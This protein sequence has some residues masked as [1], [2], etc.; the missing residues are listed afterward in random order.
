MTPSRPLYGA[1]V[2]VFRAVHAE[3]ILRLPHIATL[4][5]V[6]PWAAYGDGA[7]GFTQAQMDAVHRNARSRLQRFGDRAVLVR[8]P[9]SKAVDLV[10]SGLDFVYIDG[11]HDYDNVRGDIQRW[12][13]KVNPGGI[14]GGHDF[15]EDWPGVIRAVTEF[16][17]QNPGIQFHASPTE[18]G[19]I[20]CD[21]WVNKCL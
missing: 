18:R 9:S 13:P 8:K 10:P 7:R 14:L 11:A 20:R 12:W 4:Y 2:G 1:E 21:W 19:G 6:D 3:Q 15:C 5:C 17:H 16:L